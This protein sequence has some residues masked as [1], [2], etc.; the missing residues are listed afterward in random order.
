MLSQRAANDYERAQLILKFANLTLQDGS[1]TQVLTR[2]VDVDNA[3]EA[4]QAGRIVGIP[5]PNIS[6]VNWALRALG[7]TD[8]ALSYALQAALFARDKEFKRTIEFPPGTDMTLTIEH[9]V[10]FQAHTLPI[11]DAAFAPAPPTPAL[12]DLVH[13]EPV[14]T[15]TV[16]QT[17]SDLTNVL[18]VGSREQMDKAFQAAGWSE[19]E[20]LSVKSGL[21]TFAAVAESKGY[22]KAPVSLLLLDG[23][24]PDVVYQ[25]QTDTFAKRHHVRIWQAST[26]FDGS[27]VWITAATHDIGVA[28]QKGGRQWFHRIDPQVDR[29]RS[30]VTNDLA[31]AGAVTSLVLVER[32]NAPRDAKNA[33]GDKIVTDGKMAVVF[34]R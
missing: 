9:P 32:P 11:L 19:A 13:S 27:D 28:V 17:P 18:L 5:F 20:S 10:K 22:S 6:R 2:L 30:K 25:K 24:K 3:R 29:E 8:P 16:N 33:T 21:K 12:I 15:E 34:L 4:V 1:T 31:F 7:V 23:R 26:T 14:R